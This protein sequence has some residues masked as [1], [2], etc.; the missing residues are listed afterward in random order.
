ML[1]IRWRASEQKLLQTFVNLLF[2]ADK[3]TA[4][5]EHVGVCAVE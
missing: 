2:N 3:F 1:K 5:G 4:E